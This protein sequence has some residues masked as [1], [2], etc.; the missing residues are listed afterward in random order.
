MSH[1]RRVLLLLRSKKSHW[2]V[3]DAHSRSRLSSSAVVR[4]STAD[5]ARAP[6]GYSRSSPTRQIHWPCPPATASS[7]REAARKASLRKIGRATSELQSRQ[8]LVCRLLLEK[9]K[10]TISTPIS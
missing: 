3:S 5:R 1:Q 8:Y 6:T 2:H 4:S 7:A 10:K 9:K